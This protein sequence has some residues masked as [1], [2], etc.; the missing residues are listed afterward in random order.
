MSTTITEKMQKELDEL[1]DRLYIARN[2]QEVK[3]ILQKIT[4]IENIHLTK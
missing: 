2:A 4:K 1:Y 3:H